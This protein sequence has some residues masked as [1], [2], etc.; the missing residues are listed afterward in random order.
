MVIKFKKVRHIRSRRIYSSGRSKAESPT[1]EYQ[2]IIFVPLMAVYQRSYFLDV[3]PH[4]NESP[5]L[6]KKA[7]VDESCTKIKKRY[8]SKSRFFCV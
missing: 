6:C 1:T 4:K 8:S 3:K 5:D 2:H 7:K